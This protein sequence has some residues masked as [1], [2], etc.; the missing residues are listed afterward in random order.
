MSEDARP[1]RLVDI[2]ASV[3]GAIRLHNLVRGRLRCPGLLTS[4]AMLISS[5]V[6]PHGRPG[7]TYVER[8]KV[9]AVLL[10]RLL[11]VRAKPLRNQSWAEE[12]L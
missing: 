10:G 4:G 11:M 12:S 9:W 7:M 6:I 3:T 8:G 5:R 1:P 2:A